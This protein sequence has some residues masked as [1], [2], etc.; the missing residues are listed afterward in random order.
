MQKNI[1]N[2]HKAIDIFLFVIPTKRNERRS[3]DTPL[4]GSGQAPLA[5]LRNTSLFHN[6]NKTEQSCNADLHYT[7]KA[8]PRA[9]LSSAGEGAL[10]RRFLFLGLSAY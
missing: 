8:G 7:V 1:L 2:N 5:T 6:T 4:T 9:A 3:P 10:S